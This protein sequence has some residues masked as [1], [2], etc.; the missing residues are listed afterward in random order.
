MEEETIVRAHSLIWIDRDALRT[1][2]DE[3]TGGDGLDLIVV[4][5]TLGAIGRAKEMCEAQ[6][7]LGRRG[8]RGVR[9]V[10]RAAWP[11]QGL[12]RPLHGQSEC[13]CAEQRP[14]GT[15]DE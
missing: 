1:A 7:R 12:L 15:R 13:I 4:P 11:R 2:L 14:T 3:A 9:Y 10:W 8:R 5:G 6:T